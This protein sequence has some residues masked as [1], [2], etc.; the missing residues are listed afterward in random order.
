MPIGPWPT[1]CRVR[2]RVPVKRFSFVGTNPCP[3][4]SGLEWHTRS[5]TDCTSCPC[6]RSGLGHSVLRWR[7]R[8]DNQYEFVGI[9]VNSSSAPFIRRQLKCCLRVRRFRRSGHSRN[10]RLHPAAW[11]RWHEGV[12][13]ETVSSNTRLRHSLSTVSLVSNPAR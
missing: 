13:C 4:V 3:L 7:T 12:G 8:V 9:F 1:L 2:Y 11:Q 6:P 10:G 5:R